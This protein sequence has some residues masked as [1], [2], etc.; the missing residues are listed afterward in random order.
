MKVKLHGI[1]EM[2]RKIK[3]TLGYVCYRIVLTDFLDFFQKD[4]SD[5]LR[6]K[7]YLWFVGWAGYYAYDPMHN[8]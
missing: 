1:N 6:F 2:K 8:H 4:H 7:I 5:S 3:L